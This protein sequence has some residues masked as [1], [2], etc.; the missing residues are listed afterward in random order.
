MIGPKMTYKRESL[1]KLKSRIHTLY[2]G[3]CR[4]A[5]DLIQ[6]LEFNSLITTRII[7]L[8]SEAIW[9]LR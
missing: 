7:T 1:E 8:I 9:E 6:E 4:Q 3:D 5:E 2:G